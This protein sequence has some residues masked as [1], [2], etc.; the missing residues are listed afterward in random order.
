METYRNALCLLIAGLVLAFFVGTTIGTS[1][2]EEHAL[3]QY[4]RAT[5]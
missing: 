2:H 4:L 3:R 5:R 1:S